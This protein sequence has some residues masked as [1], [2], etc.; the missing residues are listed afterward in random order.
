MTKI[1]RCAPTR[2]R[3]SIAEDL[4]RGDLPCAVVATVGTTATTAIDPVAAIADVARK[5]GLWLHV[6]AAMAGSAMILPECR[7]MWDGIE[8]ADS[9]VVNSHKWLGVPFDCSLY[10]R[11]RPGAPGAR[12]VHESKLPALGGRRAGQELSRLGHPAR[13]TFP[14]AETVVRDPR[15]GRDRAPDS[16][17]G[18]TSPTPGASPT[19]S[20][21][22][23]DGASSR[24]FRCRRCAS[25]T[26]LPAPRAALDGE[27]LDAHTNAWVEAVNRSG[28]AYLTPAIV[29]GRWMARV[30]IGA[31]P[32]EAERRRSGVGGHA[33]GRRRKRPRDRRLRPPL[34]YPALKLAAGDARMAER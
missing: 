15:A 22:P 10:Y 34:P 25:A 7:W 24:R 8:G 33:L 27:A 29:D 14:R 12:H 20:P 5:H 23:P 13:A 6:D 31:L 28:A 2:S 19:R 11:S 18:A 4:A 16:G 32:T 21:R 9:L 1:T 26:S 17:C 30:S 3:S